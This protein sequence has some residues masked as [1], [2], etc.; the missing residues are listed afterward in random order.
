MMRHVLPLLLVAAAVR[1]TLGGVA[2]F[3]NDDA[4]IALHSARHLTLA[5]DPSYPGASPLTGATSLLHV[6]VLAAAL[7]AVPPLVALEAVAWIGA[8]F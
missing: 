4:Y 7:Q 6:L 2:T 1:I 3:P 5:E 8:F